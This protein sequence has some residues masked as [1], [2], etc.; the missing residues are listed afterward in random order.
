MRTEKMHLFITT[1]NTHM[2]YLSGLS[3][4]MHSAPTYTTCTPNH[5]P[6]AASIEADIQHKYT[7]NRNVFL[8]TRPED[9]LDPGDRAAGVS[10]AGSGASGWSSQ[11]RD[12][13][14]AE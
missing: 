7:E 9:V 12:G 8:P 5:S 3:G 2:K 13:F 10:P 11:I 6:S 14:L 4:W 1:A